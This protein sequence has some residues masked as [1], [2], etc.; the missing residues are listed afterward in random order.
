MQFDQ[1][2]QAFRPHVD[3]LI[4]DGMGNKVIYFSDPDVVAVADTYS[5]LLELVAANVDFDPDKI[6]VVTH[7]VREHRF[8]R[9]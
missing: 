2:Y 4:A 6:F 9:R 7:P 5:A 8:Q 1:R 3:R